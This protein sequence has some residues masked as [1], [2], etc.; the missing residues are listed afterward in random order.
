MKKGKVSA[1]LLRA[2]YGAAL[3]TLQDT[4]KHAIRWQDELTT[5]RAELDAA[6]RRGLELEGALYSVSNVL[7][8]WLDWA[9]ERGAITVAGHEIRDDAIRLLATLGGAEGT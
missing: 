5:L 1:R 7:G 4:S 3:D 2:E 6:K 9:H 8:F